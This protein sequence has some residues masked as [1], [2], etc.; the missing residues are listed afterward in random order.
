MFRI[1]NLKYLA[2]FLAAIFVMFTLIFPKVVYSSGFKF[3]IISVV[4][5][6]IEELKNKV[7]A[8]TIPEIPNGSSTGSVGISY[9]FTTA[10]A[11]PNGG[12]VQYR[13][14]WGDGNI[15]EYTSLVDSG[16]S[17]GMSYSYLT[18]GIYS[19]KAQAKNSK[20]IISD[21]SGS[22]T[23]T[24]TS[25]QAP[26]KPDSPSGPSTG[27]VGI[28]YTFTTSATDPDGDQVQY[29]FDWVMELRLGIRLLLIA[30]VL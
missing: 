12:Q 4:K 30:E 13:F 7:Q 18:A 29:N 2:I 28:S 16:N 22:H 24:I 19:I 26:N 11:N 15:S 17:A 27:S 9:A 25:N 6:K 20:G 8:P 1:K 10:A 3:G 21:W 14:D 23:I 5:D